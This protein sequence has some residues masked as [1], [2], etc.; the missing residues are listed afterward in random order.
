MTPED[1]FLALDPKDRDRWL[2]P[3]EA[4]FC[5]QGFERASLNR[6]LADAG[7]SKGRSYHYFDGKA[8]IYRETLKRALARN[9]HLRLGAIDQATSRDA[10]W[11]SIKALCEN[12]TLAFQQDSALAC[13]MRGLHREKGAQIAALDLT[14]TLRAEISRLID[15]GQALGAVRTDLPASLLVQTGYGLLVSIDAWF[16]ENGQNM[17]ARAERETSQD[18]LKL[19]IDMLSPRR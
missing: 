8:G 11:A 4:E 3:A 13:L 1:R 14:R 2:D 12:V 19:V 18:A 10:Y 15:K 5:A 6:M 16:A 7:E 17:S 9:E